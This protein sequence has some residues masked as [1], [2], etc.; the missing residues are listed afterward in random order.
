MREGWREKSASALCFT[1]HPDDEAGGFGGTLLRYANARGNLRRL[2]Y[3]RP[4]GKAIAHGQVGR[5]TFRHP[6]PGI[7]SRMQAAE[8]SRGTVLDY[9]DAKL[10]RQDFH[11][12]VARLTRFRP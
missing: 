3:S 9:P 12:V 11:A 10:D 7:R 8:V 6:P 5:R 2:S 4:G 1:A